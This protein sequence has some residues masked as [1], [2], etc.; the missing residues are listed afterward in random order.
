[1]YNHVEIDVW[2]NMLITTLEEEQ[3]EARVILHKN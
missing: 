1:M 2:L 3:E